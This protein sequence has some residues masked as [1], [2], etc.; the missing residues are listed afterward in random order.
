MI[1]NWLYWSVP[2]HKVRH[3]I[4]TMLFLMFVL[5]ALMGIKFTMLGNLTNLIWYDILIYFMYK[6][7]ERNK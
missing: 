4:I 5:P 6:F 1:N 7:E 2:A 3:Y